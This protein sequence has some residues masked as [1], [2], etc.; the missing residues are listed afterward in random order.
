MKKSP[1]M[2]LATMLLEMLQRYNVP[3]ELEFYPG[4]GEEEPDEQFEANELMRKLIILA[5]G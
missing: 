5:G 3:Q 1:N 4:D 2:M